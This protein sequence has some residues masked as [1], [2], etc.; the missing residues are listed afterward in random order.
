VITDLSSKKEWWA[1]GSAAGI[2]NFGTSEWL[3]KWNALAKAFWNANAATLQ[4]TQVWNEFRA[5]Y[6]C[7]AGH[8]NNKLLARHRQRRHK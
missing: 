3:E 5:F 1:S 8:P 6:P 7:R 4:Y 2:D